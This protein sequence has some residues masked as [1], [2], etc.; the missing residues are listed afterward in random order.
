MTL[1]KEQNN[2]QHLIQHQ[3]KLDRLQNLN[4]YIIYINLYF[5]LFRN[6]FRLKSN[7]DLVGLLKT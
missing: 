7:G 4:Y 2:E 1:V 3:N 5:Q 6:K